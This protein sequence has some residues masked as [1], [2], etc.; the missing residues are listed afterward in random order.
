MDKVSKKVRS[1]IMKAVKSSKNKS[2]ELRFRAALIQAR[3]SGWNVRPSTKCKPD[4]VFR[5]KKVAIFVD[6]CFWHGCPICSKHPLDNKEYWSTKIARN[7]NRDQQVRKQLNKEGWKVL[8]FWEHDIQA[9]L[10]FCISK[11]REALAT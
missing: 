4:F 8:R 2:T 6:G 7:R 3:L 1:K 11:L 10:R 5:R 9:N